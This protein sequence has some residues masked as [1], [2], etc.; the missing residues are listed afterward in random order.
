MKKIFQHL[1]NQFSA[2]TKI[3]FTR[4]TLAIE[5]QNPK[6]KTENKAYLTMPKAFDFT[7]YFD[8]NELENNAED[9]PHEKPTIDTNTEVFCMNEEKCYEMPYSSNIPEFECCIN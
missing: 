6:T 4:K 7:A 9:I 3:S 2:F 5:K 8:D 1:L